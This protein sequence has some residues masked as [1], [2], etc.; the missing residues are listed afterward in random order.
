M[1]DELAA[2]DLKPKA[3]AYVKM[4][5]SQR[6][7]LLRAVHELQ[8]RSNAHASDPL[9][10]NKVLQELNIQVGD[11]GKI[12]YTTLQDL[13][14]PRT[15]ANDMGDPPDNRDFLGFDLTDLERVPWINTPSMGTPLATTT[16]IAEVAPSSP[17]PGNAVERGGLSETDYLRGECLNSSQFNDELL[18][19]QWTSDA[20]D[21]YL[22]YEMDSA[23]SNYMD[24]DGQQQ[25]IWNDGSMDFF[26]MTVMQDVS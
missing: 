21:P 1:T 18:P 26:D 22:G 8:Q 3:P 25:Q 12:S 15:T 24:M 14:L 10:M 19:A 13:A 7:L 20:N 2:V 5:E 16:V 9:D 11:S 6:D 17:V 4:V 23:G